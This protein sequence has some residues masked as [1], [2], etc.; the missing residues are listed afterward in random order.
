VLAW[1]AERPLRGLQPVPAWQA[2]RQLR[3]LQP[4]PARQ[5]TNATARPATGC[6]HGKLKYDCV[7]C[8]PCPHGKLKSNCADCN[9]C[10]HGKREKQLRGL[11]ARARMASGK[12]TA[13]TAEPL[14]RVSRLRR[15]SVSAT[16]RSS[17]TPRSSSSIPRS[18]PTPRSSRSP[19]PS[20]V[21][22]AWTSRRA[23]TKE[24]RASTGPSSSVSSERRSSLLATRRR[25]IKK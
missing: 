14:A 11:Q 20:A 13:R 10:P 17:P 19:S 23:K 3:G 8:N 12:A 21:T 2:K 15:G 1:E 4:L 25:R 5:G 16:P 24:K 7:D 18:S 22:S 6:P 9:P